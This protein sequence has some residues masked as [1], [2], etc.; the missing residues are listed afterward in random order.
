M[1]RAANL[2]GVKEVDHVADAPLQLAFK[3]EKVPPVVAKLLQGLRRH[4]IPALSEQ[5]EGHRR[6]VYL[7]HHKFGRAGHAAVRPSLGHVRQHARHLLAQKRLQAQP[8]DLAHDPQSLEQI[9]RVAVRRTADESVRNCPEVSQGFGV[10]RVEVDARGSCGGTE[11]GAVGLLVR[12]QPLEVERAL[13]GLEGE[14][15]RC[16]FGVKH[17]VTDW[18]ESII[19]WYYIILRSV[20]DTRN[21]IE[22]TYLEP[23]L[24]F[25]DRSLEAASLR[26]AKNNPICAGDLLSCPRDYSAAYL[27]NCSIAQSLLS[28]TSLVLAAF[29]G[30]LAPSTG[31][32][33]LNTF[34]RRLRL[35]LIPNSCDSDALTSRGKRA[36]FLA[37]TASTDFTCR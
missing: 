18:R 6:A 31:G 13:E 11:E 12:E 27:F 7:L 4:V 29:H 30:R 34:R 37:R 20:L 9:D 21:W 17:L 28:I 24:C 15:D 16:G 26:E 33:S 23:D 35:I 19:S 10:L 32:R 8:L 2:G 1:V 3:A 36:S 22:C 5:P 14:Q 25:S